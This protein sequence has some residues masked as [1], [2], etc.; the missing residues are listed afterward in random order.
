MIYYLS[1]LTPPTD[2]EIF[3]RD[4]TYQDLFN[5]SY[6]QNCNDSL[7]RY[8]IINY[9]MMRCHYSFMVGNNNW[10]RMCKSDSNCINITDTC[11]VECFFSNIFNG[12]CLKNCQ[13]SCFTY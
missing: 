1:L 3:N 11:T 5:T 6:S 12:I 9:L 10:D 13:E 2:C 4:C 7:Y 8:N